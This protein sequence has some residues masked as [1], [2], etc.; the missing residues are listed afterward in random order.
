MVA[1][2]LAFVSPLSVGMEVPVCSAGP[3]CSIL[4]MP[5]WKAAH[6]FPLRFS[7]IS[8]EAQRPG[9]TID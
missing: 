4:S 7:A 2:G 6:I 5:V 3:H 1:V 9:T 8:L